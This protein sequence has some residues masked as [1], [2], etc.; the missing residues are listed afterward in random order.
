MD[1]WTSVE[2]EDT[3]DD[4]VADDEDGA[5]ELTDCCT[6]ED[7][8]EDETE[9]SGAVMDV[10]DGTELGAEMEDE[11]GAKMDVPTAVEAAEDKP[12]G[13]GDEEEEGEEVE[14]DDWQLGVADVIGML[15]RAPMFTS[16]YDGGAVCPPNRY[17]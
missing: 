12:E 17:R 16:V 10:G 14:L 5:D 8:E 1:G 13:A 4:S 15:D 6:K 7:D 2:L 11:A 9:A 3:D